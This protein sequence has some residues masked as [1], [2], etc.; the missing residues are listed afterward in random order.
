MAG[1]EAPVYTVI[2]GLGGR[3]IT[4]DSLR[5]LFG[6]AAREELEAVT[7]LDLNWSV[8]RR[9]L[10]RENAARR[11]G[12]AAESILRDLGVTGGGAY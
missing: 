10:D 8:V 3:S 6:R 4:Q 11:S 5:T 12:P 7:F 9:Q 1:L 2:A